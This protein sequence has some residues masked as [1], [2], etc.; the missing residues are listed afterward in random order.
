VVDPLCI[1]FS[2]KDPAVAAAGRSEAVAAALAASRSDIAQALLSS[3]ENMPEAV[4]DGVLHRA[5]NP[6]VRHVGV[7]LC[8]AAG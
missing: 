4:F 6:E 2:S 5:V 8:F 1:K 3:V 7:L